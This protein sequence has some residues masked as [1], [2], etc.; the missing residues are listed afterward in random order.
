MCLQASRARVKSKPGLSERKKYFTPG[1][2][3]QA[4]V[5]IAVGSGSDIAAETAGI[6][7]VKSNP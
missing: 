2:L 1:K 3:Q 4:N 7:L 6:I 5:G